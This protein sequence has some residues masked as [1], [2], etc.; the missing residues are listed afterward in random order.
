VQIFRFD[1]EVSIPIDD[2]G[3]DFRIG[4]LTGGD[5]EGR[6]QILHLGPGGRVGRHRGDL[7][8]L[9]AVV[10]GS[11]WVSGSDGMRRRIHTGQ[12]AVWEPNEVHDATS[13][14]GLTAVCVEGRF[15]MQ[16]LVVTTE[17]V[18]VDYDAAWPEWFEQIYAYVWPAV[19]R[20]ALRID[21]VGSTSVPDL[22][23]KPIID[24][25]IVV[26]EESKVRA[27]IDDLRVLDYEWL[28]ELG[29]EGR[30]AFET[31][32][33]VELPR[34]HLYLVIEN[35]KAHLDHV[36]FRDALRGDA[37]AR[38]QYADL[39][40][41]NVKIAEGDMDIYVVAKARFVADL[42][43]QVRASMGLAPVSYWLPDVPGMSP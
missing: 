2:S 16:A 19:E 7:R 1:P 6:V 29:V 9:F 28:G 31:S 15:S 12:A 43:T 26:A 38:R 13:D 36:L 25:D 23:A 5:T 10:S 37:E 24:M 20:D 27:V 30:Q 18:V 41:A 14:D 4:R 33:H 17:I 3:S 39:K 40:R 32:G 11:G 8:Q 22:A 21:H 35:N 42:L 34:H